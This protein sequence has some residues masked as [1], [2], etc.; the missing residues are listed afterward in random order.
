MPHV[1]FIQPAELVGTDRYKIGMTTKSDLSR[2][3]S[4]RVG[5]RYL[6]IMECENALETERKLISHFTDDFHLVAGK[7]YFQIKNE[8]L[9]LNLFFQIVYGTYPTQSIIL[10]DDSEEEE[11]DS[12]TIF[13][14]SGV[15][16]YVKK[17]SIILS[18]E[19]EEEEE[20]DQLII[21]NWLESDEEIKIPSYLD[22]S[23]E[24][25]E[26]HKAD[27][28]ENRKLLRLAVNNTCAFINEKFEYSECDA[29]TMTVPQLNKLFKVWMKERYSLQRNCSDNINPQSIES[30]DSRMKYRKV[31][32]CKHCKS[33]HRKNC[34]DKYARADRTSQDRIQNIKRKE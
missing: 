34:C 4:Y 16:R 26:Q 21:Q 18:D 14:D 15:L 3:R 33:I 24:E 11:E 19:S 28:L 2:V 31:K 12:Q 10:S 32:L 25:E 20:E 9:A 8:S 17:Q 1:Y 22:E 30:L 29:D 5:T 23:E 7:E 13:T 6:C 27:V